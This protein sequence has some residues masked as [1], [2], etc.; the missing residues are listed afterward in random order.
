MG[1][2]FINTGQDKRF[3]QKSA[4]MEKKPYILYG[5][6]LASLQAPDT[7]RMGNPRFY[8]V[9]ARNQPPWKINLT[10]YMDIF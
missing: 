6:I 7:F 3:C 8:R 9:S 4:P 1:V 10:Y 5:L 2:S